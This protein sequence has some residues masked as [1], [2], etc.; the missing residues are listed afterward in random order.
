MLLFALLNYTSQTCSTLFHNKKTMRNHSLKSVFTN[1][2][3]L[4]LGCRSKVRTFAKLI[5]LYSEMEFNVLFEFYF[6]FWAD[7]HLL[8]VLCLIIIGELAS[9]FKYISRFSFPSP[10]LFFSC[11]LFLFFYL[12]IYKRIYIVKDYYTVFWNKIL[13]LKLL[14]L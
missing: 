12:R 3:R 13:V 9:Y 4:H 14:F 5:E 11:R 8:I 1:Y 2:I 6:L 10:P 7:D